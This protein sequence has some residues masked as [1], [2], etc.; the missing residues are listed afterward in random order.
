MTKRNSSR[1]GLFLAYFAVVVW[2]A[3]PALAE[4]NGG[5]IN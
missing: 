2:P 1:A 5:V 3:L 4:L